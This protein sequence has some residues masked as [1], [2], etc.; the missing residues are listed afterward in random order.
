[1][2]NKECLDTQIA[3]IKEVAAAITSTN[4]L[5]S[6]TNLILDLALSYTNA[7]GGSI[8]LLDESSAENPPSG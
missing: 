8:M 6:I 4:N 5:D 2:S 1:M 7:K 3:I